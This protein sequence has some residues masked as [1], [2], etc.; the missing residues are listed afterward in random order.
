MSVE[1]RLVRL[2][3]EN[4]RLKLIGLLVLAI[5]GSVFVMGQVRPPAVVEAQRFTVRDSRGIEVASLSALSANGEPAGAWLAFIDYK[6]D[7]GPSVGTF[8]QGGGGQEG[9][10]QLNTGSGKRIVRLRTGY[11]DLDPSISVSTPSGVQWS[12]P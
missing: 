10:L 11:D 12:A 7:G 1:E 2:E 6:P 5:I 8:F 4:R 3:R 9:L